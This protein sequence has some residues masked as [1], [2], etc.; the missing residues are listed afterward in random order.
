MLDKL[1]LIPLI[2][3]AGFLLNGL[4]GKKIGNGLVTA[5][6]LASSGLTAIVS[7]LAVFQYLGAYPDHGRHL[8]RVYNWFSAAGSGPTWPS[9][10]ILSRSSC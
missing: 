2:P 1:W 5:V 6:A 3:F 8:D 4:F 10:S 9:S 7:T